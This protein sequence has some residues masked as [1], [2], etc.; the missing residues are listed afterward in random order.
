MG[1]SEGGSLERVRGR[2]ESE[3][4]EVGERRQRGGGGGDRRGKE[5]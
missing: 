4:G 5:G 3:G 2:L 1:E